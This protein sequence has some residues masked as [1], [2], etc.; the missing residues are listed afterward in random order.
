MPKDDCVGGVVGEKNI[1]FHNLKILFLFLFIQ[2]I[3]LSQQSDAGEDLF[4]SKNGLTE[5]PK[6]PFFVRFWDC[7]SGVVGEK[8][9]FFL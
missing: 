9:Y 5:A 7:V 1:F 4:F 8:K 3:T 2:H 6:S